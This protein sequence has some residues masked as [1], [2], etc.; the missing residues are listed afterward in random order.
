MQKKGER[1]TNYCYLS[2]CGTAKLQS[3]FYHLERDKSIDTVYLAFDNDDTGRE[4]A[5]AA[6]AKLIDGGFVG[7]VIDYFPPSGKDWN[8]YIHSEWV[9]L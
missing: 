9:A 2:L 5:A 6:R 1:Y 3:L 7:A 8:D 4:A